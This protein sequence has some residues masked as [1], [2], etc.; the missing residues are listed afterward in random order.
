MYNIFWGVSYARSTNKRIEIL[1]TLR[2]F[3]NDN[4]HGFLEK[5]ELI[6]RIQPNIEENVLNRNIKCLGNEGFIKVQP[7]IGGDFLAQITVDG[8][9]FLR[10]AKNESSEPINR[11]I[12]T[13]RNGI[14]Y[15]GKSRACRNPHK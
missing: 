15:I 9:D 8:I 12:G 1:R 3:Y 10:W 6:E 14:L 4:P 5:Q 2:G 13:D 11:L 7:L